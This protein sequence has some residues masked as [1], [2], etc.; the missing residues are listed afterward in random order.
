MVTLATVCIG[1]CKSSPTE[2]S[3]E[4]AK[5]QAVAPSDTRVRFVAAAPTGDVDAIMR[6]ARERARAEGRVALLYV[7]ATWCEPCQRFHHAADQGELDTQLPGLTLVE[8]DFDR[9]EGRLR[10]A[11]YT[12]RY[13]PMFAVPAADG[14][15]SNAKME[16]AVKGE[17]A[18]GVILP[19]LKG[20]LVQ[21]R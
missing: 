5:S 1:A 14:R 19:R 2:P 3:P 10:A 9:D 12:A 11:G 8:F 6:E 15:A 17:E 4:P 20:L 13:V 16:G 21:A 18:V 7:G